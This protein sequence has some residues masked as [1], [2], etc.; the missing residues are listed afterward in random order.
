MMLITE[1]SLESLVNL[2][3]LAVE[4]SHTVSDDGVVMVIAKADERRLRAVMVNE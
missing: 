2:I 4:K 1:G 3:V